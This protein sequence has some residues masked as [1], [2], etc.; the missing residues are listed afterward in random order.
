MDFVVAVKTD[1]E[2]AE[3]V[4]PAK[5]SF[6][7]PSKNAKAASVFLIPFGQVRFDPTLAK[8]LAV[9]LGVIGSISIDFVRMIFGMAGLTT[10][11]RDSVNQR[12]ELSHVMSVCSR[13]CITQRN[14]VGIS[15][16]MMFTAGFTAIRG[17]WACFLACPH[18][19]HRRTI[20][21]RSGPVDQ[22]SGTKAIEQFVVQVVPNAR[23]LPFHQSS[24]ARH[25]TSTTHLLRQ[26]FPGD[27]TFQMNRIPVNTFRSSNLGR[28]PFRLATCFGING[29]TT[30]HNSSD[31]NG[32][33]MTRYLLDHSGFQILPHTT[34]HTSSRGFC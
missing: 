2:A 33:A 13:Q 14:A 7:Y 17:I 10:H 30:A 3:V 21:R 19:S 22:I 29:S 6:R 18:G 23:F 4:Q 8:F 26:H 34:I 24:P 1:S 27:P 11:R 31:T 5:C 20:N 28:P 15:Q 32:S 9:R 25:S 12:K 16:N